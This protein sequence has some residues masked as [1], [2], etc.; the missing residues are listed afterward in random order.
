MNFYPKLHN[1]TW[2]GVV[3]KGEGTPEAVIDLDTMIE[4]TAAAEVDGVRFDGVDLFLSAPHVDIDSTDDDL[5][6]LAEKTGTRNLAIGSLVAPVWSGC[7]FGTAEQ[8]AHWLEQVRKACVI[9]RKLRDL[10]VRDYGVV[11]I[12]S[13]G[14]VAE[15]AKDAV[16]NTRKIIET[17]TEA[18]LIAEDFGE[19]LAAEGEICWGGMHSWKVMLE[20]LE[21]VGRPQT[22][23]FQA[24]MAHSMLYLL[25]YN[26]PEARM[27]P[28]DFDWSDTTTFKEAYT[29]LVTALRAWT[30]DFHVAQNDATVKGQGTHDK[31]GRHCLP[32]D[33]NGKLDLVWCA[34]LWLEGAAERGIKHLCWDGCM[35]TNQ[36]MMQP[37]T[38]NAILAAMVNVRAALA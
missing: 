30:I 9:G 18:A 26:A 13:S 31:T 29:K 22:V 11:R 8:R 24:D 4:L 2:P 25:G 12:D 32:D 23:G 28:Q 36:V 6:R 10:G 3:G 38:W 15:W 1:A 5:K 21:G 20:V 7:A 37:Q 34:G 35:F 19:R 17:F 14:G 33:P 27:V 16:G